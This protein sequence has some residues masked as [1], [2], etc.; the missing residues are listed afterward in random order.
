[1]RLTG[2]A[3]KSNFLLLLLLLLFS[4]AFFHFSCSSTTEATK[5]ISVTNTVA[6]NKT[7]TDEPVHADS[8]IEK[9]TCE[10]HP[11]FS[12]SL[13]VPNN[14]QA[15]KTWPLVIFFDP[16]A[17]G[18]L[19]LKK[20]RALANQFGFIF[21]GSNNSKNN[22]NPPGA[23]AE[24][25]KALRTDLE[26][27]LNIQKN[28]IYLAGFSGGAR[29]A[30]N[31]GLADNSVAGVI[32]NSAG[33]DPANAPLRDGFVVYGLAGDEDFNLLEQKRTEKNL[34]QY[35]SLIHQLAEFNGKHEWAPLE[36]MRD[37]F[38]FLECAARYKKISTATNTNVEDAYQSLENQ[39]KKTKDKKLRLKLLQ[40]T[41]GFSLAGICSK[42]IQREAESV[43]KSDFAKQ[44]FAEEE[45]ADAEETVLQN[46]YAQKVFTESADFWNATVANWEAT[47]KNNSKYKL[48]C[49]LQSYISMVVYISLQSPEGKQ[50]VL[51]REKLLLIYELVDPKN[52]EWAYLKAVLR[53]QQGNREEALRL[54]NECVKLNF[55]DKQRVNNQSEF[56][57]LLFESGFP[58]SLK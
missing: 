33:F 13:L 6:E 41:S 12:Y 35:P 28:R 26:K 5:K 14:Y 20:Y 58:S 32:A 54:L 1:M 29:V 8:I 57:S 27:K 40:N 23:Y 15:E 11:Q 21:A 25:Y 34:Q 7:P 55:N 53:A 22:L 38:I 37:A 31:L 50:N 52:S 2:S 19:P 16:H 10:D 39:L 51:L 36:R 4:T 3:L 49:R 43:S 18:D 42:A 44:L 46:N 48:N 56:S 17:A 9:I 47:P 24:I 45:K 30:L